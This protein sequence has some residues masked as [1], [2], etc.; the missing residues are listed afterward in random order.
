MNKLTETQKDMKTI[1]QDLK[2]F[3]NSTSVEFENH[4]K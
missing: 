4:L 1:D 3:Q 2:K